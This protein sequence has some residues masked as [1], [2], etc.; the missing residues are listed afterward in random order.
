MRLYFI[1]HGE[2]E[3]NHSDLITGQQDVPLTELGRDQAR[4]A[5]KAMRSA[6]ITIDQIVCSSLMRAHDTAKLIAHELDYSE[7]DIRVNDLVIERTFG[8]LEGHKKDEFLL[9][10]ELIK[11]SGGELD[12]HIRVR[13]QQ[14]LDSLKGTEGTVLVVSHTGFGRRLRAVVKGIATE[15]SDNFQNGVLTDLGII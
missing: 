14:F 11:Q 5:G 7:D 4:L 8:T 15:D 10:D 12:D 6:G 9:T 13:V 2:S 3:S 1:R